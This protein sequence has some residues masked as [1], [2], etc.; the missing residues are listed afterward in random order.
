MWGIFYSKIRIKS[1]NLTGLSEVLN[2]TV[3]AFFR[4][5]FGS[6]EL[7]AHSEKDALGLGST[8]RAT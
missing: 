3:K 1:R 2:K 4:F 8:V 5:L 7:N 6:V